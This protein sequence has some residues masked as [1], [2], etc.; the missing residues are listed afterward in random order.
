MRVKTFR[1]KS[2]AALFSEIKA[3]FGDSAVILSNK[4][5]EESGGK[6]HEIMVAV[7]NIENDTE[8]K[9]S[10]EQCSKDD[11]IGAAMSN[12]PEWSREWDQIKD[13]MMALLKPQMNLSLLA[14]RQRL[15]MEYLEKEGVT[16]KVILKLFRE[17]CGDKT[18]A[19][20]PALEK[21]ARI[22]PFNH[23][24]WPHK[25]HAFAG[26]H[27]VGKTSALI[28]LALKEKKENPKSR[29]CLVSADQ[30][31]G[32]GRLVLRH[33]A[34][35]SGLGFREIAS[36]EDVIALLGESPAFDRIFIDLPGLSND[37]DLETWLA[38]YG[39]DDNKDL[40]VHLVM[41]PY[42]APAQYRV[43]IRK[44][45]CPRLESVIWS[46]LDESCNYGSL[47]NMAHE[48][49]IP[50]SALSFGSGLRNSIV[51]ADEKDFW[52]LVFKHQLPGHKRNAA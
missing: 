33:Y 50:V 31:Q 27:G 49:E 24:K 13:H 32:K 17:L 10:A 16:D 30:G 29:I 15:A 3:E 25:F 36:R 39:L 14:P 1:G 11:T 42:F 52:R 44:Y 7:D 18:K 41:N 21:I 35:L 40:A 38:I 48:C 43:F 45:S 20:L 2:T 9:Y 12:I 23:K 6:I 19:V 46:K 8:V 51:E 37:T 26:P 22:C 34:D 47:I 5:V 28:R 4:S